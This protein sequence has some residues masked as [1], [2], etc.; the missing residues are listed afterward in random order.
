MT[1]KAILRRLRSIAQV[2]VINA[3]ILFALLAPLELA[4]GF[5]LKDKV[6]CQDAILHHAYCPGISSIRRLSEDDGG[7]VVDYHVNRSQVRVGSRNEVTQSTNVST[8][9][10]INVGDSFVEAAGIPFGQTVGAVMSSVSGKKVLEF[11]HS[12]WAP[13]IYFN[14]LARQTLREGVIVNVFLMV[15]DVTPH[16]EFSTLSYHKQARQAADGLYRFAAPPRDNSLGGLVARHSYLYTKLPMLE[17]GIAASVD[18]M[19]RAV[20][21]RPSEMP[22]AA[23]ESTDDFLWVDGDFSAAQSDCSKVREYRERLPQNSFGYLTYDYLSFSSMPDCWDMQQSL[24]VNAAAEDINR[25]VDLVH[26][27]NGQVT[28]YIIPPGWAFEGENL[29]GKKSYHIRERTAI[30]TIPLSDYLATLVRAPVVS[31][32]PVIKRLKIAHP[33]SFY[34]PSDGHW[35]ST[36]HRYLGEWLAGGI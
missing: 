19:R 18:F 11:G 35:T 6:Y 4:R 29:T 30:T 24:E 20:L 10:V 28:V 21:G 32:E 17:E 31:L 26:R 33:G 12:S 1:P 34:F 15:N 25:I 36:A 16:Y 13:F 2:V 23:S 3:V 9:Q 22:K 8:Y 14:W 27:A 7:A 5:W